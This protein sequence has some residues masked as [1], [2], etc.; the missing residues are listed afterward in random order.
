MRIVF[1]GTSEFALPSL[2]ALVSSKHE[3]AAVVTQSDR[4]KGRGLKVGFSSIKKLALE[5]FLVIYQPEDIKNDDF[6]KDISK[7]SPQLLIVVSYGKILPKEIL[8]IPQNCALNLHASLLPKY[9][10]AAPVNWAIINGE[11]ETGA[12][13]IEMNE[14]MDRGPILASQKVKIEAEDTAGSLSRRLAVLGA[15]I[16]LK[17]VD[18]IDKSELSPLFQ[19]EKSATYAPKLKKENGRIDWSKPSDELYNFIRGMDPQPGAFTYIDGKLLKVWKVNPLSMI[20]RY[21]PGEIIEVKKDQGLVVSAGKG[22]LLITELQ[23]EGKKRMGAVE[24][25]RGYSLAPGRKLR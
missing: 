17:A 23:I 12:S 5:N 14:Y 11:K 18:S 25:I 15:D 6:I 24:F 22:V 10:G 13:I 16:L 1:F 20:K 21:S 19:D 7:Y 9:R 2:K 4:K 8:D 3:V